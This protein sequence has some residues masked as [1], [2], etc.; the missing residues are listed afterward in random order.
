MPLAT[1]VNPQNQPS[2]P[3]DTVDASAA[4]TYITAN[5]TSTPMAYN[6][7]KLFKLPRINLDGTDEFLTLDIS[8][9]TTSRAEFGPSSVNYIG[10]EFHL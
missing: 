5:T 8:V 1:F 3:F 6:M 2:E 9:V 4:P 7:I 10:L